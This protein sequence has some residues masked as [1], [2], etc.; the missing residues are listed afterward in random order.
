MWVKGCSPTRFWLESELPHD[1]EKDAETTM[2]LDVMGRY[3]N[4]HAVLLPSSLLPNQDASNDEGRVKLQDE[5]PGEC[6]T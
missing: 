4:E 6:N 1:T 5:Q 3:F 2:V